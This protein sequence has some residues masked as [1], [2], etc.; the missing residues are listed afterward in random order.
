MYE[1]PRKE[2]NP[3]EHLRKYPAQF[4]KKYSYPFVLGKDQ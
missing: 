3:E 1:N 2:P 4:N